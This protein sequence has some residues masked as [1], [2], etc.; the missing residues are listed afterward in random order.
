MSQGRHLVG[1]LEA[2]F[3]FHA[4]GRMGRPQEVSEVVH[5][6]ATDDAAFVTGQV[7]GV[8]GGYYAHQPTTVQMAELARQAT[9]VS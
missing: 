8:D 1:R 5:F 6:L 2:D 9:A 3:P 7:I 4:I